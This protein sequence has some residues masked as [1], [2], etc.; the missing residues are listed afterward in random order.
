[1]YEPTGFEEKIYNMLEGN[2][3]QMVH[4]FR[5][6]G[7]W[8]CSCRDDLKMLSHETSNARPDDSKTIHKEFQQR[9]PYIYDA[10]WSRFSHAM[11]HTRPVEQAHGR[12]RHSWDSQR[13]IFRNNMQLDYKM[14]IEF[15]LIRERKI[16]KYESRGKSEEQEKA[17]KK[18][19]TKHNDSKD[20]CLM[21]GQQLHDFVNSRYTDAAIADWH[22]KENLA[23]NTITKTKRRGMRILDE[24][25]AD[26][27][28]QHSITR[29]HKRK[30]NPKSSYTEVTHEE[31]VAAAR[32]KRPKND[33]EWAF[34]VKREQYEKARG[35]GGVLTKT[36]WNRVP[37]EIFMGEIKRVLPLFAKYIVSWPK[38]KQN[39]DYI[40]RV[41]TKDDKDKPTNILVKY[42]KAVKD[43]ADGKLEKRALL[44][45]ERARALASSSKYD[46]VAEFVKV[47]ESQH[48]ASLEKEESEAL[49]D[50]KEVMHANGPNATN[51]LGKQFQP[52]NEFKRY[53]I[54]FEHR[55][56]QYEDN[57][58]DDGGC[59]AR[60]P[61][62]CWWQLDEN[63]NPIIN[64]EEGE[65]DEGENAEEN[66]NE[67]EAKE[68]EE[69]EA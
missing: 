20:L 23:N 5:L 52:V 28:E 36:F 57:N 32:K 35:P 65:L 69:T 64:T 50:V 15:G 47:D 48:L 59:I 2:E 12:Q 25:F 3:K 38:S 1:M 19:S 60:E 4:S 18:I 43:I 34:A 67:E 11:G 27:R 16:Y 44:S 9:Y 68:E 31:Y 63:S 26:K 24:E 62:Y 51:I 66:E 53:R 46:I 42:V 13:S 22:T 45:E 21:G 17:V 6:L 7:L 54:T 49:K 56:V 55:S 58:E 8:K 37:K 61:R 30:R 39:R 10:L 41:A 14:R 29:Q 33:R 40:M